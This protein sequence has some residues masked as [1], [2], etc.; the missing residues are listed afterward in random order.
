M[1]KKETKKIQRRTCIYL[2]KGIASVMHMC[3]R[4][5]FF[6]QKAIELDHVDLTR[7]RPAPHHY[8][9][10]LITFSSIFLSFEEVFHLI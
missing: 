7:F 1:Q 8:K 10:L 4:H 6:L 9:D 3:E 2:I 5:L